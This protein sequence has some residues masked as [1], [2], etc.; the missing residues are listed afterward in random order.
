MEVGKCCVQVCY[1]VVSNRLFRFFFFVC[2]TETPFSFVVSPRVGE[3]GVLGMRRDRNQ[4]KI[5]ARNRGGKKNDPKAI[6]L[7]R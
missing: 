6:N 4:N 1:S 5:S 2:W 3:G 7:E